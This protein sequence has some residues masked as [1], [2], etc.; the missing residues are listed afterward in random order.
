MND[1]IGNCLLDLSGKPESFCVYRLYM[2]CGA[3]DQRVQAPFVILSN[4]SGPLMGHQ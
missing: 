2:L 4:V 3:L 1:K